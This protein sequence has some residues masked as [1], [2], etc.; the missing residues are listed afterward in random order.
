MSLEAGRRGIERA[1]NSVRSGGVLELGFFGGEPLLEADL[2]AE[3]IDYAQQLA[4]TAGISLRPGL[5]TNGTLRTAAA[6][7]VM[8]RSNLDLS[9]SCDG[10]P[11]TH[12]RHRRALNGCGSSERVLD[13]IGRLR[14]AGRDFRVMMVVR[15]DSVTQLALGIECLRARGVRQIDLALDVWAAWESSD[16]VQL[17]EALIQAATLWRNG[18]PDG[19]INWF[20]E[21]AARLASLPVNSSA[22]C[23]FGDGEIAVAASGNLYP[24]ERLIGEDKSDSPMRLTGHVLDGDDFFQWPA[25]ERSDPACFACDIASHCNTTCRCNNYIRT[26]NVEQPDALLCLLERVTCRETARVLCKS[27]LFCNEVFSIEESLS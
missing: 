7:A 20:D 6:W 1:V 2:V 22:R 19:S 10:L 17:E 9:V 26:G 8:M 21:K 23:G 15:P 24:C 14:E 18:L 3:L 25:S 4:E 13:T 11:D 16:V 12:D 5:T 27:S